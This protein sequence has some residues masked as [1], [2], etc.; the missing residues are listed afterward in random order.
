MFDSCVDHYSIEDNAKLNRLM[1]YCVGREY[2]EI[3]P[4]AMSEPSIGYRKARE[5]L[6]SRFGNIYS[7]THGFKE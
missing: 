6:A 1:Q 4:Y 3:E 5:L 7:M 2:K